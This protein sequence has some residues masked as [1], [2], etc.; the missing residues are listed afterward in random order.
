MAGK[1]LPYVQLKQRRATKNT[2]YVL[3]WNR[4]V[5]GHILL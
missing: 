1:I 2:R 5:S 4:H 3:Q